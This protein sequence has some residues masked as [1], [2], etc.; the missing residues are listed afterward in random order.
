MEYEAGF[1]DAEQWF[2][3]E[4]RF[5]HEKVVAKLLEAKGFQAFSPTYSCDEEPAGKVREAEK[6]LFPGY[7]FGRFNLRF[8][9]PIL[10]T[11]GIHRV[12]GY[13]RVPA[14]IAAEEI[15]AIL[16]VV[17]S[18]VPAEPY[19][20][21]ETGRRVRI[22]Q[23]PLAGV[24]G[25]LLETR[26]SCRVVLSVSLIQRSIRIEVDRAVLRP[27]DVPEKIHPASTSQPRLVYTTVACQKS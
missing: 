14:S 22:V 15:S 3:L 4:V 16:D 26:S 9:L 21:L 17:R 25:L 2:A 1:P 13:G 27:V 11:P 7:V 20:F 5:H 18:K 12:V 8:R 24:E 23:G 19:A 6:F 10:T